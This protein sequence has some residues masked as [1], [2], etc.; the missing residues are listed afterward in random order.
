MNFNGARTSEDV[1]SSMTSFTFCS[2]TS[3]TLRR[4]RSERR[5]GIGDGLEDGGRRPTAGAI[6]GGGEPAGKAFT[7]A[8]SGVRDFAADGVCVVGALSAVRTGGDGG[9]ES[10]SPFQSGA[11]GGG[12]RTAG[13]QLRQRYPDWGARKLQVLLAQQ[14]LALPA[15]TIHRI[16]LR[17]HLVRAEDRHEHAVQ[18]FERAQ[19]NELWQMDFKSPLGWDTHVGPLSV[20]DDH[21]RYMTVLG[22]TKST[23]AELVRE[24]LESGFGRCGVPQGM[25]MDHG[26]PWW[27]VNS[28]GG[29]TGLAIWLMQQG[30]RLR[31]SGLRHPQTQGKVE[32]FHGSLERSM[33]LRGLP[34]EHRQAWLD[35]Y[36]QEYNEVRP[37]EAL[38]MRTPA[39]VWRK[40]ERVYDPQPRRWEYAENTDVR[41]INAQ[42]YLSVRGFRWYCRPLANQWVQLMT[43]EQ[44]ILVYYCQTVVCELD[45]GSHRSTAVERWLPP[46]TKL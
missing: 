37:H 16:L 21:S 27:N 22:E 39:S 44:R 5:R 45:L 32:R 14:G 15:S 25:L 43:M 18:R 36:R 6:C 23:R 10:A 7:A 8:L 29:I 46:T 13:I 20:L 34:R 4:E 41:K 33:K 12:T 2:G 42:G 31:W 17:H 26:V 40:S 9:T 11:H 24:Q 19:P 30:I 3:F 28:A 35:A 38:G 1:C